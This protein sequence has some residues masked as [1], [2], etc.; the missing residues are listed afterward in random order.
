MHSHEEPQINGAGLLNAYKLGAVAQRLKEKCKGKSLFCFKEGILKE[1]NYHFDLEKLDKDLKP[2]LNRVFPSCFGEERSSSF[3]EVSNC[4]EKR[5]VFQRLRKAIFLEPSGSKEL[6]K[7]LSCIYKEGG[8]LQNA[9]ALDKLALA[10]GSKEEARAS[11]KKIAK[12]E[13]KEK[14]KISNRTIRLMLGMGGFEE[15]FNLF[16]EKRAVRMAGAMGKS[17]LRLINRAFDTDDPELQQTAVIAAG[18][19]GE[20]GLPIVKEAFSTNEYGL[21]KAAVVAAGNLGELGLP[22][23][24]EALNGDDPEFQEGAVMVASRMGETGVPIVERA[25]RSGSLSLEK[26]TVGIASKMGEPGVSILEEAFDSVDYFVQLEIMGAV[27]RLGEPALPLAKK[28]FD[29]NDLN[30]QS[31]A[32]SAASNM[33]EPGLPILEK[34]FNISHPELQ[35]KAVKETSRIG[36]PALPLFRRALENTNLHENTREA[37]KQQIVRLEQ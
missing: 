11:V 26:K 35:M 10:L 22:I 3:L 5:E 18:K 37:I 32:M 7:S 21:K 9:E 36:R 29:S 15:E 6:L 31:L 24:E 16:K 8:F 13:K 1:E 4:N 2:D 19:M 25:L 28:A 14:G 20:P 27:N 33:G 12:K 30:L 17:G 34:G 23:I